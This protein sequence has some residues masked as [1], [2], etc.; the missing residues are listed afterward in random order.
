MSD[1][2]RPTSAPAPDLVAKRLAGLEAQVAAGTRDARSPVL[3]PPE[4]A[5]QARLTFP[6]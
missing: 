6:P 3:I 2:A 1:L 4:L 5:V